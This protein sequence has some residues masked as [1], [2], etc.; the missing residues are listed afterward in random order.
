MQDISNIMVLLLQEFFKQ[1]IFVKLIIVCMLVYGIIKG[2]IVIPFIPIGKRKATH[3]S[4]D[5][6]LKIWAIKTMETL[7]E[8]MNHVEVAHSNILSKM[9]GVYAELTT[10][11]TYIQ[12]YFLLIDKI[13]GK[14]K[15][16]VRKWLKENHYTDKTEVEF[17]LYIKENTELL[18]NIVVKD[19]NTFYTD[20]YFVD[21]PREVLQ[22]ANTQQLIPFAKEAWREMFYYCREISRKKEKL[23]AEI[24]KGSKLCL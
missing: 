1:T 4:V 6:E 20:D 14:C 8:Q 17:N 3:P 22:T 23:I 24:E 9:E 7:Y 13:E 5:K 2:I 16:K 15:G 10:N 19:L 18:L 12:H 11:R 21:V